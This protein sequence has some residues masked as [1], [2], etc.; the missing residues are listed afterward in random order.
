MIG[1]RALGVVDGQ[2]VFVRSDGVAM[3]VAF[4]VTAK[5]VSGMP[6]QVQDGMRRGDKAPAFMN[7]DGGWSRASRRASAAAVV[8]RSFRNG[9]TGGGCRGTI[10]AVQSAPPAAAGGCLGAGDGNIWIHDIAN[11][12][13]TPLTTAGGARNA[14]VARWPPRAISTRGGRAALR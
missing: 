12:T 4:D 5:R 13:L 8:G 11:G 9:P 10:S 1:V 14:V 3:A 6:V 2:L 7:N